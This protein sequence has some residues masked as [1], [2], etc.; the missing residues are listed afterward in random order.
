MYSTGD[1]HTHTYAY[2][3]GTVLGAKSTVESTYFCLRGTFILFRKMEK[4]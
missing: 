3:L 1:T 2:M 4:H